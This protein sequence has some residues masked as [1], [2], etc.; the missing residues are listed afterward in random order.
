M[1]VRKAMRLPHVME[2]VGDA[3]ATIYAKIAK[4]IF[5]AGVRLNPKGRTVVWFEDEIEAY[6]KGEWKPVAEG[7]KAA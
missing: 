1:A 6:Q 4:G 2:A 5:P 3:K 7:A